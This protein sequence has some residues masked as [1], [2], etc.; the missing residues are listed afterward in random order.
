MSE[1]AG[2]KCIPCKVG[3]PP[4]SGEELLEFYHQLPDEWQLVNDH[5]IE[6]T[7]SF[8]DFKKALA[9]V[10]EVGKIAEEE[11]HH[12][13][14]ELSWGK[15]KLTYWTHK[16]DGLSEADFVMAAKSD[17]FYISHGSK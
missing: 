10:V 13:N 11:G 1:L 6:R 15:V 5:Q 8:Q 2:K 12:P 7:Y 14:I 17:V 16:I 4:L 9:F 3:T